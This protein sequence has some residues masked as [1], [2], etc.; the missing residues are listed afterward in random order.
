[1]IWPAEQLAQPPGAPLPAG[2]T[3]RT[4]QPGDEQAFYR[5]MDKVG[6][7]DWDDAR[8]RPWLYRILPE[9]WFFIFEQG[10]GQM[11]ATSMATHDPTWEQPFCGEV[12]WTAADPAHAGRGLG[13]AVVAPV[14]ARLL[15]G[16][17]TC[18]H[19]Y[20]EEWRLAAITVYLQL[21]FV[22]YLK[23]ESAREKWKQICEQ[24]A[25]PYTPA[26]WRVG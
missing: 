1:M 4:Y 26:Q 16:G 2:Y 9:G 20:T 23:A 14:V 12:G 15:A 7:H 21:G 17:Y 8:L 10:S 3:L 18:I 25:R 13:R 22:P 24:L 11:V 5:L 19:L 6:W